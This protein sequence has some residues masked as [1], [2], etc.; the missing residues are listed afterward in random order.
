MVP[1]IRATH[2]HYKRLFLLD[3][4]AIDDIVVVVLRLL[5][6]RILHIVRLKI[7]SIVIVV[8]CNE[9]LLDLLSQVGLS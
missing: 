7:F 9:H 8:I 5:I 6:N 4:F 3:L 2:F 1:R